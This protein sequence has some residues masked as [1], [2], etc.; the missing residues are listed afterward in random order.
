[1]DFVSLMKTQ[2]DG[3]LIGLDLMSPGEGQTKVDLNLS[4]SAAEK[5][6]L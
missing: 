3:S 6:Q 4:V 5:Q 1:M 2:A